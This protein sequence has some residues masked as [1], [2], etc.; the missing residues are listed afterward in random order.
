MIVMV[1]FD[2][3]IRNE[4]L[5]YANIFTMVNFYSEEVLSHARKSAIVSNE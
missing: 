1:R 5:S 3:M 2:A 4:I